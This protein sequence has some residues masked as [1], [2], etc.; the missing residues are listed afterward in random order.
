MNISHLANLLLAEA[1]SGAGRVVYELSRL[2]DY[3]DN[4]L[5]IALLTVAVVVLVSLVMFL[6]RRDTV[7]L[8]RGLR[9]TLAGL[10]FV[11]LAGLL[12]FFLG[13]ER[14]TTREVVH[15]SQVAVLVDVSQSMALNEGEAGENAKPVSRMDEVVSTLTKSPLVEELRMSHDVH[16]ARFDKEVQPVVSLPKTTDAKGK[17]LDSMGRQ[18]AES[19]AAL[20]TLHH[21]ASNGSV[22]GAGVDGSDKAAVDWSAELSPQGAET[23]LGDA[24]DE[25]LR[26]YRNAPLA[27]VVVISDGAQNAGMEPSSAAEVAKEAKVPIYTIGIGSTRPRRNVA[28]SD[29]LVPSRAFPGDSVTITGYLQATGYAG[30]FIDVELLRRGADEAGGAGTSNATQRVALGADGE[31]VPVSFE[32]KPDEPKRYVYQFRVAAPPDDDNPRDNQRESE[33]DVVDHKTRVLLFASGPT[34][35]YRFLRDQLHR[36]PTMKVDVLLQT[37]QPGISQDAND[38]LTNFPA[39]RDDLYQYDCIVAFDPDWTKLDAAQ[40]ALVESW[41]SEEAGGMIVVPGPIHSAKWIRSTEHT[42]LLDL[43]PVVFQQRLTLMDD[44]HFKGDTAW[45]IEF[46][47][48]GRDARF[49]WL[50]NTAEES[51]AAWSSFP[52]VYGYYAIK[53][54]K[55]GAT[56]YARV[57]DPESG[58]GDQHPAFIASQ[59]YGAGQV[60]YIGSGEFWRLRAIDTTYFEVLYTKLIRHVSQ[61]RLLR[62][63]SRGALLVDRDRYELGDTVVLRARLS[64]ARHEPLTQDTVVAQVMRPDNMT[65]PVKLQ[66]DAQHPGMYLGQFAAHQEGTY[67][68]VLPVPDSNEEPFSK[69]IQVRVP[70]LERA[71]PERNEP[72]L[73]SLAKET[74]GRY[75]AQLEDAVRGNGEVKSLADSIQSR[76]EMKL[77]KGAPDPDFA[78]WQMRSLLGVI[79]GALFIEWIVRRLNRLA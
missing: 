36:D 76:A 73:A 21:V 4:R 37:A 39:T 7:E 17:P 11:A 25:Q 3:D 61:G 10:R 51:E 27:G 8:S 34:R 15:N 56:V 23:R 35:D 28:V 70:D 1:D 71:H 50:A 59:F 52:G 57:G 78:Q 55:P 47:R 41:V 30:R 69:Y 44:G 6:Y 14:R 9:V 20:P 63:S 54:E 22:P 49:L 19:G 12:V 77:L 13:V 42:K 32:I 16:V 40:V 43:Y 48:A 2:H 67:Q 24:L 38:I 45:P 79:A 33:M 68:V 53:G 5:P 26:L 60:L 72:L 64:N 74:G 31:I 75:Y 29:L 62:G 18:G 66:A 65:N 46:D 58:V